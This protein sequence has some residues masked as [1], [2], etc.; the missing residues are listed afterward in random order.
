M[1]KLGDKVKDSITGFT[2]IVIARATY[3]N[4]CISCEV[5]STKL[6]DG[7]PLKCHWFDE[8]RLDKTSK[9]TAGGPKDRM[10]ERQ[11]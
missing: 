11:P 4:G 6:K 10:P 5:E 8:Q 7:A 2:G 9:A 3:L 1:I